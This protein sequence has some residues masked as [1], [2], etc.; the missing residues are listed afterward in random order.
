MVVP[1][2]ALDEI[3]DGGGY[4]GSKKDRDQGIGIRDLGEVVDWLAAAQVEADGEGREDE[5]FDGFEGQGWDGKVADGPV[6]VS[7]DRE[8]VGEVE[9][10][11]AVD[12][13]EV[14]CAEEDDEEGFGAEEVLEAG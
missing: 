10:C 6:G 11:E 14:G 9:R 3:G 13:G 2:G 5:E 1:A 8:C 4:G 12:G 7:E